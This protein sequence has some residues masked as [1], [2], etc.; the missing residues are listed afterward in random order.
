MFVFL[1]TYFISIIIWTLKLEQ[2][3]PLVVGYGMHI[4]RLAIFF[5]MLVVLIIFL[6][7]RVLFIIHIIVS[8]I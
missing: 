6:Y 5:T 8:E 4:L 7:V 3:T 1:F 2:I